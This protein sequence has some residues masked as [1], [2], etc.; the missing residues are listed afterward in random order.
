[1]NSKTAFRDTLQGRR[2]GRPVF[3]PFIYGLAAKIDQIPLRE[4]V[5]DAGYY[6]HALEEAH[7]LFGYDGIV[8]HWDTTIE[9]EAFGCEPDWHGEY[10]APRISGCNRVDWQDLDPQASSRIRVL[11]E[12]TKRVVITRGREIPVIGTVVGPC[13]LVKTLMGYEAGEKQIETDRAI[14][15]A[16]SFLTKLIRQLCELRVDAL[17]FREDPLGASFHDALLSQSNAYSAVYRT[18]FNLIRHYNGFPVLIVRDTDPDILSQVKD[19]LGPAGI[20]LLGT[21]MGIDDLVVLKQ[22]S[23]SLKIS[24]GLPLPLGDEADLWQRFDLF[25]NF[26]GK[27]GPQGFYYVSEGEVPH[28][29][30]LEIFHN[31]MAKI[32]NT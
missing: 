15:L 5:S 18:Q 23:E 9:A 14:P 10:L 17:F 28:D 4:M 19:L 31:L 1:M 26:L 27:E 21:G 11:I 24:F 2:R 32:R 22:L 20:I 12:A 13:T 8:N 30:P 3:V 16:Q 6:T 29:M 25:N 7:N